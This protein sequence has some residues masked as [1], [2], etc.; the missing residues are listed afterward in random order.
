MKIKKCTSCKAPNKGGWFYCKKCG[1][2]ASV[3][4]FTTNLY[5]ISDMGKRT[6]VEL[7]EQSIDQNIKEMNER[8]Y[9]G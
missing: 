5:M 6:D 1:K 9:A 8:T 2:K 4:P 3:S 7:S